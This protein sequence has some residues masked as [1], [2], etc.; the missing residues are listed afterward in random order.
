MGFAV[1]PSVSLL[2]FKRTV[3]LY[4]LLPRSRFFGTGRL[5]RTPEKNCPALELLPRQKDCYRMGKVWNWFLLTIYF[6]FAFSHSLLELLLEVKTLHPLLKVHDSRLKQ[7]RKM[8]III[9]G[10]FIRPLWAIIIH[11]L[12]WSLTNTNSTKINVCNTFA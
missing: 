5:L 10:A 3:L 6:W 11:Q 1:T 9:L 7:E 8:S 4:I 12:E 2:F